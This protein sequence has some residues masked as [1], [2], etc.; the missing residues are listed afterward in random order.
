MIYLI[1]PRNTTKP[2]NFELL[3]AL[4]NFGLRY[5]FIGI[6]PKSIENSPV[7]SCNHFMPFSRGLLGKLPKVA[8]FVGNVSQTPEIISGWMNF[9]RVLKK[10][11]IVHILWVTSP[12][13]ESIILPSLCGK[14]RKLVHT[15]HNLL[16][17][18]ERESDYQRFKKI[19]PAFD[20]IF[21]HS[22]HTKREFLHLFPSIKEEVVSVIPVGN[23]ENFYR[24]HDK[25]TEANKYKFDTRVFLFMGP[26][27]PYKGFG[28]LCNAA[29]SLEDKYFKILVHAKWAPEESYFT[30]HSSPLPYQ[31]LGILYRSSD[32]VL[33]P[34]TKI[35]LATSLLE[36]A[37]FAKPVIA[38]RVGALQ[39]IVRDGKDGF[40]VKPGSVEELKEAMERI[41]NMS[42]KELKEMG[43][44]LKQRSIEKFP[45][46]QVASQF[47]EIY[48]MEPRIA[49]I[50]RIKKSARR[51]SQIK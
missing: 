46:T 23:Y 37:Y 35:S 40:L 15:A 33:L 49:R 8:R 44:S 36:A 34:Y 47:A 9:K 51:Y 28:V 2:Y 12:S 31:E 6:M 16:P 14:I 41:L 5:K 13:V 17:H 26:I 1:D 21:L 4:K 48:E 29:K 25:T 32:V 11:D 42:E 39:D 50:K 3:W 20:H 18:R 38:S 45:W 24:T 10:E 43:E 22:S 30:K 19:Y 27:K 7:H